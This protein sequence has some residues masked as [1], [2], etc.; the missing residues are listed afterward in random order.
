MF[1]LFLLINLYSDSSQSALKY[2]KNT[3]VNINN[4]LIMT[5]D[6]NIRD[7]IWDS[8]F[9]HHFQHSSVLFDI[10]DSFCLELSRPTEQIPTRY[11]DN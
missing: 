1:S 5:G 4:I 10:A 2:L 8:G 7:N 9:P 6:L 3:E 11:S